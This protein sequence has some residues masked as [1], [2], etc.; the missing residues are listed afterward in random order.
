MTGN[1]QAV[2]VFLEDLAGRLASGNIDL[3]P[4]PQIA[5]RVREILGQEDT[6]A[7]KVARLALLDPVLAGRIFK[8]ANSAMFSRSAGATSDIKT[9]IGR[10]GFD[11]VKTLAFEV[12]L[13]QTFELGAGSRLVGLSRSIRG[14]S[15]Q[16]AVLAYLIAKRYAPGVKAGDAMLA[17]LLHEVGKLYIVGQADAYPALFS[18]PSRLEQLLDDWHAGIGH[19]ILD[20]WELPEAIV[21]AVGEQDA[22]DNAPFGA[23]TV[24]VVLAA[25][26]DLSPLCTGVSEQDKEAALCRPAVQRLNLDDTM[27]RPLIDQTKALSASVASLLN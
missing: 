13:D 16:V 11:M 4:C 22:V 24:T 19:A 27:V 18:D 3:P 9:A 12:A 20:A 8:L 2:L 25:A 14:H 7:E 21:T 23:V 15:R 1:E 17:G 10:I 26:S 5:L 6:T